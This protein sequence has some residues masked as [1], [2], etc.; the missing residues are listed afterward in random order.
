[1]P[2]LKP[3]QKTVSITELAPEVLRRG[4]TITFVATGGSMWPH[5]REGDVITA[6]PLTAGENPSVGC[7]VVYL[8]SGD[9]ISVHRVVGVDGDALSVRG[10]AQTGAPERVRRDD[11]LGRVTLRQRGC[12]LVD[13]TTRIRTAESQLIAHGGSVRVHVTLLLRRA[14]HAFRRRSAS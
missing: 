12:R 1:M 4:G 6:Q 14:I 5:I 7:P 3:E 13:L 2:E 9:R 10:D 8:T 11:V